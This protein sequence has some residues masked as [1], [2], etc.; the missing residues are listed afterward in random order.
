MK[1]FISTLFLSLSFGFVTGAHAEDAF[2]ETGKAESDYIMSEYDVTPVSFNDVSSDSWEEEVISL[3]VQEGVMNGYGDNTFQPKGN[4]TRA[5]ALKVIISAAKIPYEYD[6]DFAFSDVDSSEWYAPYFSTAKKMASANGNKFEDK[7]Y[8]NQYITRAEATKFVLKTFQLSIPDSVDQS[9][10]VDVMAD[11]WY[12]PYIAIAGERD[13]VLGSPEANYFPNQLM[14]RSDLLT[15]VFRSRRIG[16]ERDNVTVDANTAPSDVSISPVEGTYTEAILVS[17]GAKNESAICYTTNGEIPSCSSSGSCSAGSSYESPFYFTETGTIHA[18]ACNSKGSSNSV[19]SSYFIQADEES[20]G[21]PYAVDFSP[22][23]GTYYQ[24]TYV[25]LDSYNSDTICYSTSSNITP[26][27]SYDGYSC[28]SGTRYDRGLYLNGGRT[29]TAVA[30]NSE[31]SSNIEQQYYNIRY[32]SY[33]NDNCYYDNYGN[34]HCNNDYYDD[35]YYNDHNDCYYDNY[36]NYRCDYDYNDDD[37]YDYYDYDDDYYDYDDDDYY[38]DDGDDTIII[39]PDNGDDGE[40]EN[41]RIPSRPGHTPLNPTNPSDPQNPVPMNPGDGATI[42]PVKNPNSGGATI[43][44]VKKPAQKPATTQPVKKPST[45]KKPA[46]TQPVKKPAQKP[47]KKPTAQPTKPAQKPATTQPVKKP[48][49]PKKPATT[50]PVKKPAQKP[51][52]KPTAQ[53][54]K[55]AQKPAT[56][57]PVKKP[58]KPVQ[59]PT[60]QPQKKPQAQKPAQKPQ[61]QKSAPKPQKPQ[62]SVSGG[63]K[64]NLTNQ[65][66]NI[67]SGLR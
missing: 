67:P 65:Q 14:T 6:P 4:V 12:A 24:K 49:T 35:Y 52:K 15:L 62:P 41:D 13:I 43:Q 44:P 51:Q 55:P 20:Y 29:I 66:I 19:Q 2:L 9:P 59:K 32:N 8:P 58:Q 45:P 50:Q 56:T 38:Y 39:I 37:Y 36:G 28:D 27:C 63:A 25:Y 16:R 64:G 42:Q 30:C 61:V 33:Y 48:S 7:A 23:G 11:I 31:G 1:Y 57:Q 22:S 53:P 5:E 47:Q 60:Q 54:T 34:Y 10:F 3:A 40:E 21:L 18:I 17:I 46:T 26:R